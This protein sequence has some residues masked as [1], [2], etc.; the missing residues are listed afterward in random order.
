MGNQECIPIPPPVNTS[1]PCN[2]N[3]GD[4]YRIPNFCAP[5]ANIT[6]PNR[7]PNPA[8]ELYCGKLSEAN[9]WEGGVPDTSPNSG[10]IYNTDN[11][12]QQ[13]CQGPNGYGDICR[14]KSMTGNPVQ[15]CLNNYNCNQN[16]NLC[17]SDIEQNNTCPNGINGPNYRNI[18]SKDCQLAL[19]DYCVGADDETTSW[20][21]RWTINN[22]L[23]GSCTNAVIDNMFAIPGTPCPIVPEPIPNIC[24]IEPAL[25]I[26]SP[27]FFWSQQVVAGMLEKYTSQ[28]FVLGSLPSMVGY[29]PFQDFIYQKI[30]CPYPGLCAAGLTNACSN[31]TAQQLSFNPNANLWCGC[32]LNPAEYLPYSEQFNIEPQC[33]PMCTPS[34]TIPI[35]GINNKPVICTE[36][37]CIVN[38]ITIN[39]INAQIDGGVNLN[40]VCGNCGDGTCSC[41][42]SNNNITVVNSSIG[43]NLTPILQQCGNL[44]CTQLNPG[45]TGPNTITTDCSSEIFNPYTTYDSNLNNLIEN[46]SK[47]S[48]ITTI[49]LIAL[50]MI[51]IF[52]LIYFLY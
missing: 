44:S 21:D 36:N 28:G 43:G 40:Q 32:H 37:I 4:T 23:T 13:W 25:P 3:I 16:N 9:E 15:C 26:S 6:D 52:V 22:G 18:T 38:D 27:G 5:Q 30:C 14:R 47:N 48:I 19:Y 50:G 17:F 20:I 24:N 33:T 34:N 46:N 45:A 7:I 11:N 49:L 2:V 29:N 41:I 8:F 10:C 39:L 35:V 1:N 12:V 51:V 31:F 42:V